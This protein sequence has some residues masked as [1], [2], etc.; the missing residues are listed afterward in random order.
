MTFLFPPMKIRSLGCVI[1]FSCVL[2]SPLWAQDASPVDLKALTALLKQIKE[3]RTA[4]EKS[5]VDRVLQDFRAA[6]ASNDAAI[7]F[8]AQAIGATQFDGKTHELTEFQEWKKREADNLKSAAMQNAARLHLSYALLTIQRAGGMTTKQLEPALSAHIAAVTAA[9][10]ADAA[11]LARREKAQDLKEAGHRQNNGGKQPE[12]EPLFWDQDL[13]KRGVDNGIFVQWYGI[14]KTFANL[15]DWET[16]PGNLDGIYQKTLLPYYRQ[17]KD[18]RVIAY[19]DDKI[20]QEAQK[21]SSSALSF[22]I[23]Q[24]N[25]VTRPQLLWKRATDMEV[26]GQ[27]NRALG[28]MMSLVKNFPDHPDLAEWISTLE[29]M[30]LA[31][32]PPAPAPAAASPAPAAASPA[33]AAAPSH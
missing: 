10:A 21:A 28:E 30:L 27:R 23:D 14:S 31:L 11:V 33:P 18:P 22:K 13:I 4:T 1:V 7:A 3:M 15:K 29:S 12:K 9:G 17:N 6:A 2:A 32:V 8:Y 20:Q 19:W 5:K 16:S 26:I 24:F 25:K